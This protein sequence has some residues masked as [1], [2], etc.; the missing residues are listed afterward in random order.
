[1]ARNCDPLVLH[2]GAVLTALTLVNNRTMHCY[3]IPMGHMKNGYLLGGQNATV[4]DVNECQCE[5]KDYD[6]HLR[7]VV[8]NL[9]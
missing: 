3:K 7:G 1:M 8:Y 9:Q 6:S 2:L 4:G 5:N